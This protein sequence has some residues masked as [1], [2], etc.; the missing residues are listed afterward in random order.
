LRHNQWSAGRPIFWYCFRTSLVID[1]STSANGLI[2]LLTNQIRKSIHSHTPLDKWVYPIPSHL[3][4]FILTICFCFHQN[5]R[6][7]K[8]ILYFEDSWNKFDHRKGKTITTKAWSY[9]LTAY[10][11]EIRLPLDG[12]VYTVLNPTEPEWPIQ[13]LFLDFTL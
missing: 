13:K 2:R 8:P 10:N 11:T 6:T 7:S 12:A 3:F 1:F 5:D 9:S 4:L